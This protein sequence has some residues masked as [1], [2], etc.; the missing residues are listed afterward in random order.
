MKTHESNQRITSHLKGYPVKDYF[1]GFDIGTNSVGWAATDTQYKL[2]K[3]NSHKM[4]GSR[5]FDEGSTAAERRSFRSA[6]RRLRRRKF[7]LALLEELFAVEMAKV[8][9]TFFLRL[10]ESKY[11]YEDK[12]DGAKHRYTLFID[13]SYTDADYFKAFPT[14]YHL[15]AELMGSDMMKNEPIDRSYIDIRHLFLA[16]HHII[17]YR[18]NFIYEGAI[19]NGNG[20]L[21]NILKDALKRIE[22]HYIN[23]EAIVPSVSAIL[24]EKGVTK[25]DTV[26]RIENLAKDLVA[27]AKKEKIVVDCSGELIDDKKRLSAFAKL[28]LGLSANLQD[29]FGTIEDIEPAQGKLQISGDTYDDVRDEL[30]KVWGDAMISIDSCKAVYDAIILMN[31]KEPD[32]TISESKVKAYKTHKEDLILLKSL[33][34]GDCKRYHDMFKADKKG[35]N[36][37]VL[38]I[39]Q[40]KT[41][42][43]S[44]S[45]E[46]F[47][48]YVTTVLKDL[49]DSPERAA[50][51]AKIQLQTFLPLQRIKDNGVIPYQLHRE[52]L[53]AILRNAASKFPFLNEVSDGYTTV[54]K[55]IKLLEFRIPYYVGPLNTAHATKQ[56]NFA[57]AVRKEAGR[58]LPWNF[59]EKIDEAKSATAF[60]ENLTNKCT[61]LFGEHV[62]PKQSL[63]YSEFSL[64]NELNNVRCNDKPLP[65]H[66]KQHLI[67]AVFKTDHKK[68]TKGRISQFLIDNNY[69]TGKPDIT[70]IDVDIKSDLTSYRDMERIFGANFDVSMAEDI[71]RYITLFG[72]SK[73]MLKQT[74]KANFGSLSDDQVEKVSK[75]RYRDWGR[76]SR[77]FLAQIQG[78]QIDGDGT[79]KSII[80]AMRTTE[81]NLMQLLSDSFSFMEIV[82]EYNNQVMGDTDIDPYALIQDMGLSPAVKRSVWQALRLLDEIVTIKKAVPKKLFI[83]VARTNKAEKKKKSSRQERL[84]ELYKSIKDESRNWSQE[85]ESLAPTQLNSKKLYLYYTQ[86]G[87]CM[88]TGEP[89]NVEEL[90]GHYDIDH[91]YPRS[92]TKDDSFDNLV[93]VKKC[94]NAEKSDVYPIAKDIQE[95]RY[96]FWTQL[97]R[98]GLISERKYARLTR[99]TELT[100]DDLSQFVAR[101]LVETNQSVKAVTTILKQLYPDTD[102]VYV[103]AEN[104]SD[105]RHDNDFIKVRSIN[106]HHHAKDAYL[107]IVVGNVYH[108]RF[109]KNFRRFIQDNGM[110]RSYNLARMFDYDIMKAGSNT[111][112]V[113]DAQTSMDTVRNMMASNDVRVT[114]KLTEQTGAFSDATVYKA[115]VAAKAGEGVYLSMK[116]KDAR[117]A[118]VSKYGGMTKIKNA[119]Y[120][121]IQYEDKKGKIIKEII[122]LPVY[123]V[124]KGFDESLVIDY[125]Q[126]V[127]PEAKNIEIIYKKLCINQLVKINGFYYYLGGKTNQ[128]IYIDSAVSVIVPLDKTRYIKLLDKFATLR[129]DNKDIPVDG[130]ISGDKENETYITINANDNV[131][132]Y[133]YLVNK[134][135]TGIFVNKKGNKSADLS[136]IGR[137]KFM[138]LSLDIQS[139]VLLNVLNLI[140]NNITIYDIKIL[141]ITAS[142]STIGTKIQGLDEF[143]IINQ[144]ITGLYSNEIKI[145]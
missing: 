13:P 42:T 14:I 58:V 35:H 83:E 25:S 118:D 129:K 33:L 139:F 104:V 124:Q 122:P 135:N 26:K 142:R 27:K 80:E 79:A 53:E 68:M 110:K 97:L 121:I 102:V 16:I 60:I 36:N 59:S 34:K 128:N 90:N 70:G 41:D 17:K 131:K 50:I 24:T 69:V 78:C 40:G 6:R 138:I 140:T 88:Y 117:L 38:Y 9:P 141:D 67:D 127:N 32:L 136:D 119:H 106:N 56:G 115:N 134:M 95:S 101:Q 99:T 81:Y 10:H 52:E 73:K 144:S 19:F 105:F 37:Y 89:I 61:Y 85:I 132:L 51:E 21:T 92:L 93:L 29:L 11:H 113:W 22:F 71:I 28:V 63:L 64:L 98:D 45:Q 75:L 46:D 20:D 125:V 66:V 114:K 54:D 44:C 15:R 49:P 12:A 72:D 100:V 107:N 31:I 57:W 30:A 120:T 116:T 145:I 103:K 3:C 18:G 43:T 137:N 76:L 82:K 39:K 91:I 123:I 23:N 87:R 77:K 65:V 47:Y 84:V 62:L 111:E 7:R 143:I 126:F 109:T 133:D 4:W 86:M 5:L 108:E 55:I 112:K 74:V 94:V 1:V 8:D 48:K 96:G 2:L 130:I